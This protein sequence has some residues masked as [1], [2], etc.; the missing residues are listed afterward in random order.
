M[1]NENN[2]RR[3]KKER[4][5]DEEEEEAV[6]LRIR[7][8]RMLHCCSQSVVCLHTAHPLKSK[9][10]HKHTQ[11]INNKFHSNDAYAARSSKIAVTF[12]PCILQYAFVVM[13]RW[14]PHV[15]ASFCVCRMH[16]SLTRFV[17]D[18]SIL[19]KS[20][21][22]WANLEVVLV[23]RVKHEHKTSCNAV[24]ALEEPLNG[25]PG[26]QCWMQMAI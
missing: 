14:W 3:N 16:L 21:A 9:P 4:E 24:R 13:T 25:V 26:S 17:R 15:C 7:F 18:V 6:K 22:R 12:A 10:K 1:A 5:R 20:F 23:R 8:H 19:T 11:Q 2:F